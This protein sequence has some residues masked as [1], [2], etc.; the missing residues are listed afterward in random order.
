MIFQRSV[1]ALFVVLLSGIQTAVSQ[2]V[3]V[4]DIARMQTVTSSLI[5]EDGK[6]IAYTLSV[7]ADPVKENL[8]ATNHLYVLNTQTGIS[9]PYYTTASVSQLAFRPQKN[10]L[11]FVSRKSGEN[12]NGIFELDLTGGEAVKIFSFTSNISGY[13]WHPN[14]N[15]IAFNTLERGTAPVSNLAYKPDFYEENI[16]ERKA[17]IVDV[18][19]PTNVQPILAEGSVYR[20][21]WSPDGSKLAISVTPTASVDDS[22]MK[23]AVKIVDATSGKII[24]SVNNQ[25]KL[26]SI[27][28]SPDGS[29]L[30]LLA[31][32]DIHDPI[33]GSILIVSAQG[34]TP[35]IIDADVAGKYE[36]IYW[37]DNQTISYR[38]SESTSSSIGTIRPDGSQ[39]KVIFKSD[40]HS[41]TS[42]SK[43]GGNLYSFVASTPE[44][45]AEVY[46]LEDGRKVNVTKRTDNNTWL[47]SRKLGKQEVITYKTRDGQYEIDGMLIYPVNYQA[48]TRVPVITVVHGGPEAHY[49]NGWLTAY[50][51][52]GQMAAARGYAVFYPNYRGSTGRGTA[53]TYSSQG[54]MAGKEFDDIVDGIDYLIAQGIADKNRI[55]VTG[56][57]Y[58]GYASAW[59]STYYSDRFAAAVMFVG[60]SNNLSK[61]GTSD[62][63]DELYYVHARERIWDNWQGMLER[64]P[65]YY[66]DRSQTPILIMHG[67]E[68][69][70]VHPAQSM[71]LYRHLKVRKPEVPVRLIYYPNEGHGNIRSGSRYDYNLRMLQWFDTYL[72]TG[73]RTATMP[74][75]DLPKLD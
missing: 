59:M 66:V 16:G 33:D 18:T 38:M 9:K 53:F 41:I 2:G 40:T 28:W 13:N 34:G 27:H 45:P 50:S 73:D 44:H 51:M 70:R 3:T 37:T 72:K 4:D 43:S 57:S 30:A 32:K 7:P 17:Y 21:V 36:Q 75:L 69:T 10:T 47:A 56:G 20:H 60:I 62:I 22:Y 68:D 35:Q 5:S 31:A 14:G 39:R 15:K 74:S 58:G 65:I 52:P 6:Y 1:L 24:A 8:P 29:R 55:G 48:G 61:W 64:S 19:H 71:E 25:G 54:D 42:F 67:A 12:T 46:T 23:Q 26:S 11:T 49:S 63:P